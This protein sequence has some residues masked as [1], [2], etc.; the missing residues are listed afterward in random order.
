WSR[1]GGAAFVWPGRCRS[2]LSRLLTRRLAGEAGEHLLDGQ[3]QAREDLAAV[4]GIRLG[5]RDGLIG[6]REDLDSARP[7]VHEPDH[8]DAR[9]KIVLEFPLHLSGRIPLAEHFNG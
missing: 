9:D 2:V 5:K 3:G 8:L 6:G 1:E 4:E 7:G